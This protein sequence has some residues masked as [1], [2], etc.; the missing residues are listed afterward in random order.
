M[1]SRKMPVLGNHMQPEVK[2]TW[3]CQDI[4]PPSLQSMKD[5][6]FIVAF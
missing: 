6:D 4:K 3:K 2:F 1:K 5:Y